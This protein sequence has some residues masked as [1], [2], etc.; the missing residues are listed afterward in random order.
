M[1]LTE[2]L[3]AASA[4]PPPTSIDLERL[5]AREDRRRA[6]VRWLAAGCAVAVVATAATAGVQLVDGPRANQ[7]VENAFSPDRLPS[8]ADLP[9]AEQVWPDATHRLPLRLPDGSEYTVHAVLGDGRYLI[10]PAGPMERSPSPSIF[11][12]DEGKVTT[13]APQADDGMVEAR[14]LMAKVAG[15]QVVWMLEG[16][17]ASGGGGVRELWAVRLDQSQARR[18]ARLADGAAP[19]FSVAGDAVVWTQ[20]ARGTEDP[21]KP[22]TD[23]WR[24]PLAG[25]RAAL[26][27]GAQGWTLAYDGP[28]LTDRPDWSGST[29]A[30]SGQLWNAA[31]NQKLRWTTH[32]DAPRVVC[33][34]KWCSGSTPDGK[35]MLQRLDATGYLALP[36]EGSLSSTQDGRLAVGRL[37][38]EGADVDVVWDRT[39]GRAAVSRRHTALG[40]DAPPSDTP[41]FGFDSETADFDPP[42]RAWR[43]D[44]NLMV[45][46]LTAIR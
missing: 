11:E 31:T 30:R 23:I 5:V 6:R 8:L 9:A 12:P 28:W 24:V 19:R 35:V 29:Q 2:Q 4:D 17:P 21:N 44:K 10:G 45:L 38:G 34:P 36:Y 37:V 32:P 27:P 22:L 39:T 1:N 14:V 25:G 26:L 18:L 16:F 33:G 42:V 3:R 13:L 40:H 41:R 46:D 7:R 15:D 43:T 20:S